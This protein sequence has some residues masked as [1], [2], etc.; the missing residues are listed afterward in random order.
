MHWWLGFNSAIVAI[1]FLV[2][3]GTVDGI[4]PVGRHNIPTN[5]QETVRTATIIAA[6]NTQAVGVLIVGGVLSGGFLSIAL[7]AWNSYRLGGIWL[8]I[9]YTDRL[10]AW[11]MIQYVPLEFAA[12]VLA[13]SSCNVLALTLWHW[14]QEGPFYEGRR[15]VQWALGSLILIIVGAVLEALV[16]YWI[17]M[18]S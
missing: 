6:R 1:G 14:L 3:A 13:C 7:L 4:E 11:L 12:M 16:G 15:G 8:R 5:A 18:L 10:V 9:W 2:G 17:S